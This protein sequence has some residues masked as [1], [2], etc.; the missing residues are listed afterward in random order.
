M[1]LNLLLLGLNAV[2]AD[3]CASVPPS[4]WCA[5]DELSKQ[6]GFEDLCSRTV[7]L[8][9]NTKRRSAGSIALNLV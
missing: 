5:N 2:S 9:A 1:L 6:C 8:R 3:H 7:R 4:L